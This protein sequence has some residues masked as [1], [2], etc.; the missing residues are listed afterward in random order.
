MVLNG[1]AAPRPAEEGEVAALGPPGSTSA[2]RC[3][4]A[5]GF[6]DAFLAARPP[7]GCG[8]DDL[9]DACA[10]ATAARR[11]ARGEALSFPES[12]TRDGFG[13]AMTIRA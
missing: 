4:V 5:A 10:C 7:R 1:D 6:D 13:L 2:G 12:P 8:L 9:L 3:C 11:I